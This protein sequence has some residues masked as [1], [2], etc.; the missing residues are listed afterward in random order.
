MINDKKNACVPGHEWAAKLLMADYL[1]KHSKRRYIP[2]KPIQVFH[3]T[4]SY[5]QICEDMCKHQGSDYD[6]LR[7]R[8]KSSQF[9]ML[10]AKWMSQMYDKILS[11]QNN[12]H[13]IST[14]YRHL[15][16]QHIELI[17]EEIEENNL[18]PS[19]IKDYGL[20][21]VDI[22]IDE[23]F[24]SAVELQQVNICY[25]KRCIHCINTFN[26]NAA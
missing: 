21:D 26:K 10:S 17:H 1:S 22:E 16:N 6:M 9:D 5:K 25:P 2:I 11:K 12:I 8:M 23:C 20:H 15:M 7:D 24:C 4:H 13:N 14:N 19:V 3:W 18:K